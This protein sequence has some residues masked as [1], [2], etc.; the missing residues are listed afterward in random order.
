MDSNYFQS[1]PRPGV[2]KCPDLVPCWMPKNGARDSGVTTM[3][4]DED[5]LRKAKE[6]A[7]AVL[8]GDIPILEAAD[9]LRSVLIDTRLGGS[10]PSLLFSGVSSETDGLPIGTVRQYWAK[11]ALEEKD[12]QAADYEA[13]IRNQFLAACRDVIGLIGDINSQ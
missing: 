5:Q 2:A 7:E 12:R 10:Q 4:S 8:R 9:I 1:S 13:R 3:A 6:T 11:T